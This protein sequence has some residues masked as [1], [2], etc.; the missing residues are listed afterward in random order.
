MNGPSLY[1]GAPKLKEKSKKKT[2]EKTENQKAITN[3]IDEGL[4]PQPNTKEKLKQYGEAY[5]DEKSV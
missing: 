3:A 2:S 1:K 5:F 4:V